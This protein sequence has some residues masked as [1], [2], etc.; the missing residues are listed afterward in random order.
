[1]NRLAIFISVQLVMLED[2]VARYSS[3]ITNLNEQI[4][5]ANSSFGS[6]KDALAKLQ[7]AV[8]MTAYNACSCDSQCFS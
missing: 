7:K 1:M 2:Q 5:E 3:T 4:R 6:T 8:K